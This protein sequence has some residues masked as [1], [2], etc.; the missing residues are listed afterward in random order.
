MCSRLGAV[1][2]E[3]LAQAKRSFWRPGGVNFRMLRAVRLAERAAWGPKR[4]PRLDEVHDRA[5]RAGETLIF[6][7][8][9]RFGIQNII[10][11]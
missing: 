11:S 3:H 6:D 10:V 7:V 8:V 4:A 1:R 9:G 2:F 5:P